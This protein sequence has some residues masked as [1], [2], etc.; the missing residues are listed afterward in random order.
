M[1]YTQQTPYHLR[2]I[3]A[4]IHTEAW[5]QTKFLNWFL[6]SAGPQAQYVDPRT[7]QL[8]I[9]DGGL[10]E[11]IGEGLE[12]L[13]LTNFTNSKPGQVSGGIQD[14]PQQ[15]IVLN[16]RSVK[17]MYLTTRLV[18]PQNLVDAWKN[19]RIM[20]V[21]DLMETSV[22]KVLK[23]LTNQ[24]DQFLCYG[25]DMKTQLAGDFN[26]GE[27]DFEG[28]F[29]HS[30]FQT[31]AAGADT[32]N[33]ISA[34]NDLFSSYLTARTALENNRYDAPPYFILSD[35][36]TKAEFEAHVYSAV[37]QKEFT[38]FMNEYGP[39]GIK[40]IAGWIQ[41][42]NAYAGSATTTSRMLVTQPFISQNG[43]NME[44]AYKLYLGYNFRIF[45]LYNGGLNH[46][47]EY[48]AV[49]VWSGRF[50]PIH[51]TSYAL[52]KSGDLVL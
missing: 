3:D 33:D 16:Q 11:N 30:N 48:E 18:I 7:G 44:P 38:A 10:V 39:Q 28:L 9:K 36:A 27:G 20:K 40:E 49:I 4:R 31:F 19:N 1:S 37:P 2:W 14:A 43:K 47:L 13:V 46:D 34:T 35:N 41:S 22:T 23:A 25:D 52:Y 6:G 8:S 15:K 5:Q 29:N 21:K 50:E 24:V 51:E 45:W 32:D 12:E 17:L 42:P 26:A